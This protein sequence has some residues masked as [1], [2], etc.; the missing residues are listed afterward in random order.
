MNGINPDE[1]RTADWMYSFRL[2]LPSATSSRSSSVGNRISQNNT[3][4]NRNDMQDNKNNASKIKI[5]II[6]EF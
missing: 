5:L 3:I 4:V 6:E 1:K 2:Q